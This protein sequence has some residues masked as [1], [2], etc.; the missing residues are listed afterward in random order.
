MILNIR[1]KKELGYTSRHHMAAVADWLYISRGSATEYTFFSPTIQNYKQ[2]GGTLHIVSLSNI[3][4]KL[5]PIHIV[6]Y[7]LFQVFF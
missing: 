2:N 7:S 4:L 5:I 1:G 3:V 6:T